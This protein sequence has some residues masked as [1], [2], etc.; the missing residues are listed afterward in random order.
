MLITPIRGS[1]ANGCSRSLAAP[2]G[3]G[4]WRSAASGSR[5]CWLVFAV[6]AGILAGWGSIGLALDITGYSATAN[7]RFASG[8]P[9]APTAN[10]NASF[11]GLPYD[12]S[13]VGWSATDGTKGFGFI[14][15]QHYLV[16]RHYGGAATIRLVS[17]D[18]TLRSVSQ[19]SV[20]NTNYG[21]IFSGQTVGDLSIGKLTSPFSTA[22]SIA[23]YPVL[24][25]NASSTTNT[26]YN[27][28]PLLV[29]GRGPNG[30][31]S[32]RV[33]AATVNGTFISGF[34]SA[35]TTSYADVQLQTGD[36]GSP[37][38]IPW[39]NPDGAAELTILGNNA[40]TDFSTLNAFNYF[41]NSTVM[42]VMNGIINPDGFA[43]RVTGNPTSAWEG[44]VG[45]PTADNLGQ[46]TNWSGNSVPTDLYTR[47]DADV[48][49]SLTPNVNV[50]TNLRGLFFLS[51]AGSSDGFT[52]SGAN[53]LTI[54]RGGV[55]NY[56]A[57]RQ[58][59]SAP[60]T[61]G[62]SQYWDVGAGGVTAAAI[63]T[64]GNLLEVA[65]TGTA[66]LSGNVSGTGGVAL[67]GSRLEMTGTSS[68]T[69][70]TWV[71]AGT[72]AVDGSI[73][74]S[75]G[76]TVNAGGILG[77]SGTVSAI[78]GSGSVG[79]GQSPGILTGTSVSPSGGLDFSFEFTQTGSPTWNAAT[80]SGNDV[81]RLTDA[82]SPFASSLTSVNEIDIY[83]DVGSLTLGD[84]FRG[85]FFTDRSVDFISSL[86]NASFTYFLASGTG[87]VTYNGVSYDPYAGPLSFDWSTVAETA[88]FAGGSQTGFV[89]QFV[90]VPEPAT[91]GLLVGAGVVG[92]SGW[93]RRRSRNRC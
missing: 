86:D 73:A 64:G 48:A 68:Y 81:L 65:G 55:V 32:P 56:D 22:W 10:T 85:G 53:A 30:S 52:F 47:F 46:S 31:S 70:G 16:A 59:F 4:L 49:S 23:R 63:T 19:Q 41:A 5:R 36:S 57:D 78:S 28:A 42:G 12:W 90:A 58:T 76:V 18:G 43:L 50:P 93:W 39:T 17:P 83:L 34:E 66:I 71:H 74:S 72:L 24:D 15:P 11:I 7:D 82:S 9:T 89:S 25:A 8:F 62:A 13:G 88:T 54:G 87:T 26:S 60:I 3:G 45:G 1:R 80:A 14:T 51:T 6:T 92:A 40:G 29:Y 35:V 75:S 84:T 61:L 33:G 37:I 21:V 2:V 44:G 67:S 79:P 77:G 91:L 20:T 69:G 27:T 38:F